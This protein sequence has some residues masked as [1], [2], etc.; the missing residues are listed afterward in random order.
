MK[1]WVTSS[2]K[3]LFTHADLSHLSTV[4]LGAV[5]WLVTLIR[6]F[7]L[8]MKGQMSSKMNNR[9]VYCSRLYGIWGIWG[10][11]GTLRSLLNKLAHLIENESI[12]ESQFTK[13]AVLI[14]PNVFLF[15]NQK[16]LK[17]ANRTVIFIKKSQ[18]VLQKTVANRQV[19]TYSFKIHENMLYTHYWPFHL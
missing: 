10:I 5:E 12:Y 8:F 9:P 4:K 18:F 1:V 2:T 6:I 14:W 17:N 7:R 11:W 16:R 3:Y 13:F 15:K 19:K